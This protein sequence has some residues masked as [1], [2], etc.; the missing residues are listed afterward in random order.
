MYNL[1]EL[2]RKL[3]QQV[4]QPNTTMLATD[5]LEPNNFLSELDQDFLRRFSLLLEQHLD[6]EQL[7][8]EE[9]A[10]KMFISRSQLHRKL[11]ALTDQNATDF[12]RDYRLNQAMEMLKNKEGM[13]SEVASRV[14][15]ANEKYFSTAFKAKFGVS[16]SRV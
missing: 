9:F 15:F 11:K 6:D 12:I 4:R 2:R 10:Q 3:R 16:P 14:G 5:N 7:G 13:V 8:V 1:L